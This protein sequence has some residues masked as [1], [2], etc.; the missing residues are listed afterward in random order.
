MAFERVDGVHD[1]TD[2]VWTW[3]SWVVHGVAGLSIAAFFWGITSSL[4]LLLPLVWFSIQIW[5]SKTFQHWYHNRRQIH[6][7][8]NAAR[9][10]AKEQVLL[11]K[12]DALELRRQARVEARELVAKAASDAAVH[13]AKETTAVKLH[14]PPV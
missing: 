12:I 7:A 1:F 10:K 3:L 6:W 14:V 5:E 13:L 4:G 9:L 11:A 8:K 2:T